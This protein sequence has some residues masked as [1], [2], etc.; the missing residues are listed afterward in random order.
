MDSAMAEVRE[1][2]KELK[3]ETRRVFESMY[4]QNLNLVLKMKKFLFYK[5]YYERHR[6]KCICKGGKRAELERRGW[7][8][9]A[10]GDISG[11]PFPE[12]GIKI[13]S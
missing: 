5:R 3:G 4:R 8:L 1:M 6:K 7:N 9:K 2:L 10:G 12:M 11:K 13:I